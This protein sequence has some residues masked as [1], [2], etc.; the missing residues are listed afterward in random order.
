VSSAA[1]FTV[2]E[3]VVAALLAVLFLDEELGDWSWFGMALVVLGLV[4]LAAPERSGGGPDASA[5]GR[6]PRQTTEDYEVASY[7]S[8]GGDL[9]AETFSVGL[10]KT[11]SQRVYESAPAS[12]R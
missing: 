3:P 8:P 11:R 9:Q 12:P 5:A 10:S 4:I 6:T 7:D 1:L 2:F